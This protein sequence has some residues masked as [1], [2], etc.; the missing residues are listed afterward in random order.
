MSRQAAAF[1]STTAASPSRATRSRSRPRTSGAILVRP[2]Q[3]TGLQNY[4]RRTSPTPALRALDLE[5]PVHRDA[6]HRDHRRPRLRLRLRADPQLHAGQGRCSRPIAMVPIL[7]PSLLP[8]HR[9]RLPVRQPGHDQGRP[10]RPRHLRPDR[11][12]H[13]LGLLHLPARAR[14]HPGGARRSPMP[15]CT[16]RRC[17]CARRKWRIFRTVTLPGARYGLIS[18]AF[19][20]FN[21]AITDFGV[22]KVIGGQYN[23]LALD[24]YKQV[25]G[26]QNFEM[27]AVVSVVLLVPA[28]VAFAVDRLV[29]RRRWRCCRRARCPT[30]PSPSRGFDLAMLALLLRWSRCSS[31]AFSASASSRRWSSSG[32]T[33]STL[34]PQEL[35]VRPGRRR[36]LGVLLQLDPDGA[37]HRGDRHRRGLPRRLR[38]REGARLRR[39]AARRSTCSR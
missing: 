19:V 35:P 13:R 30:R 6:H 23:V 9:P 7:V 10:A 31:S 27:G 18:A 11:H 16:R 4:R 15:G 34:E 38:G 25:V 1:C 39:R 12:R 17:R 36:R 37:V 33:T 28:V 3:L 21:L 29:Q 26:Q 32:R 24:I 2:A 20:V 5:Q 8:G 22:P 14:D